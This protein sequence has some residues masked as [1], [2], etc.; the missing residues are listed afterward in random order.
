MIARDL[1]DAAGILKG[2]V[3]TKSR[4]VSKQL[5]FYEK[6]RSIKIGEAM[7]HDYQGAT[8]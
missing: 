7:L 6:E 2:S 8:K 4:L 1:A 5:N 3:N